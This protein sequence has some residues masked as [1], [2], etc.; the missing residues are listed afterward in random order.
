[1]TASTEIL[2]KALKAVGG[3]EMWVSPSLA[4]RILGNVLR[5]HEAVAS[6]MTGL[7]RREWEILA[8][9]ARGDPQATVIPMARL[10]PG[11]KRNGK[12]FGMD[13]PV[14]LKVL[15]RGKRHEA[16]RGEVVDVGVGGARLHLSQPLPVGTRVMLDI[17][18]PTGG[19][20]TTV[21][22]EGTVTRAQ[23]QPRYEIV[24]RFHRSGRILRSELEALFTLPPSP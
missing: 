23:E 5:W 14:S 13:C 18:F 20:A 15:S 1:M 3:G 11:E 17:C 2:T 6:D 19:A 9:V 8:H 22:F 21:R 7:T 24:V 12:R 10:G 4:T 16:E